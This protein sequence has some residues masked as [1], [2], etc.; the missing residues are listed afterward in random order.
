MKRCRRQ[1]DRRDDRSK[2]NLGDSDLT[3]KNYHLAFLALGR[4]SN[5]LRIIEACES[6]ELHAPPVITI[7]NKIDVEAFIR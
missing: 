3:N 6:G 2:W 7:A 4:G 1:A 5:M